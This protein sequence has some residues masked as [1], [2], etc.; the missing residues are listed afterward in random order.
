MLSPSVQDN[1]RDII[2]NIAFGAGLMF[3]FRSKWLKEKMA[4]Y[5][6]ARV[7][8]NNKIAT[9]NTRLDELEGQIKVLEIQRSGFLEMSADFDTLLALVSSYSDM[10]VAGDRELIE[11]LKV[12]RERRMRESNELRIRYQRE[13][14]A[15]KPRE[16]RS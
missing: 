10:F 7:D 2:G 16:E 8:A 1:L 3:G 15:L 9:L 14:E 4:D 11:R 6:Q 12:S 13:R 5:E